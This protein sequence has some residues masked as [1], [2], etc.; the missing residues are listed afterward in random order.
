MLMLVAH[1]APLTRAPLA[2]PMPVATI[3]QEAALL[4]KMKPKRVLES[5]ADKLG[6]QDF[7]ITECDHVPLPAKQLDLSLSR[8][9]GKT[10]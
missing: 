6:L 10:A 2:E 8:R 4:L 5:I 3:T 9:R 7:E 1:T